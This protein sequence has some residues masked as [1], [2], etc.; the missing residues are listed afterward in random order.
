MAIAMFLFSTNKGARDPP[1]RPPRSLLLFPGLQGTGHGAGD[2][3]SAGL[4]ALDGNR[5]RLSAMFIPTPS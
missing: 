2:L 1:G 3:R 4:H 5:D